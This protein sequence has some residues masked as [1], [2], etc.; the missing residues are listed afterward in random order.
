MSPRFASLL[1]ILPLLV[2]LPGRGGA[3]EPLRLVT[4]GDSITR[5]LQVKPDETFAALVQKALIAK[6]IPTEVTNA[7][8]GG[9]TADALTK[10]Q[11]GVIARK[12]H[13]VTIMYGTND[14]SVGKGETESRNSLAEYE[15][16]LR[17]MITALKAA[18][19]QVVVMTSP[20]FAE[21]GPPNP[22]GEDRNVRLV[23]YVDACRAVAK[24]LQ[25]PL[26]D[27]HAHWSAAAAKG[28]KLKT[29]TT[30]FCHPNARG[31]R[32]LADEILRVVAPLVEGERKDKGPGKA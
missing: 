13:L 21:G 8:I 24:E 7:G 28:E 2:L 5:G 3:V 17:A 1:L 15:S 4:V 16:A 20:P 10:L 31:H 27:H 22:L 25:V 14:S 23:R 12:P 11:A 32:E 29:W 6:G 9:D 30:D 19:I 18:G 26:V